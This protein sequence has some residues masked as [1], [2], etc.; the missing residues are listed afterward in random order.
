LHKED[1][2]RGINSLRNYVSEK[3]YYV[4]GITFLSNYILKSC[5]ICLAKS[6]RVKFKREP[7]KQI[8]TNYPKQRYVMDLTELSLEFQKIKK[9]YLFYIID[10]FSKYEM[11]YIIDNKEAK[12]I[13]RYLKL[14][15]ECNGFPEE[16]GSDNGKEFKNILIENY[17]KENDITF[18]HGAPYNPHS[19]RVVEKFHQIIKDL[20]YSIYAEEKLEDNIKE[21]LETAL[22]KI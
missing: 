12:T 11:A 16:I 2:H 17:L 10:H 15:L 14:S 19:Q 4:E 7:P 5:V 21:Y 22:K 9:L 20:L 8:I 13:L 1:N 6:S 18:I 3:G